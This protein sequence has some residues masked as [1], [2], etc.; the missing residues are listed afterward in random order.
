MP[1]LDAHKGDCQGDVALRMPLTST[2]KSFMRCDRHW[3]L[4]LEEQERINERYP[5]SPLP[6]AW[7][8]PLAAG[9]SWDDE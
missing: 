9:E 1:C 3:D 2:G 5:D 6:P 4:R 7:F 8:D